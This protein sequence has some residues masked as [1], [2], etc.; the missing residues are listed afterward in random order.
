[1]T[2]AAVMVMVGVFVAVITARLAVVAAGIATAVDRYRVIPVRGVASRH[3]PG[4]GRRQ[5][6]HE[7]DGNQEM[8]DGSLGAAHRRIVHKRRGSGYLGKHQCQRLLTRTASRYR[9]S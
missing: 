9:K 2:G 4:E 5:H 7:Q 6:R 8:G 3:L 1:M